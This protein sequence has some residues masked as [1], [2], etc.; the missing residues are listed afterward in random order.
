MKAEVSISNASIA[1]STGPSTPDRPDE[2]EGGRR[3]RK[4]GRGPVLRARARHDAS[5]TASGP[6]PPA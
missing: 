1:R 4:D 5:N 3:R 2:V 6:Q